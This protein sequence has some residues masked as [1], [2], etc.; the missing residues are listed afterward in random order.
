MMIVLLRTILQTGLFITAHDAMHGLLLPVSSSWNHRVGAACLWFYAALPYR[1]CRH[2]HQRHH[3]HSGSDLD[4][5]FCG[6]PSVGVLGWYCRF[7]AGYLS[8]GQMLQLLSGWGLMTWS[9]GSLHAHGWISVLLVCV[10]PLFL[11][12]LQL[13]LFG[14]YLPHRSQQGPH[15]MER[16]SSLD[17]PGWLSLLAC[18]HFGYHREHHDHPH[19]AWFQLPS[20]HGAPSRW[21]AAS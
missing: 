11:S 8:P 18:F 4:P 16:P 21:L 17:L 20:V 13:F 15:G 10:L 14:T 6:D 2:Q 7:M 5:D 1:R 19:L 9:L 12:S 3:A